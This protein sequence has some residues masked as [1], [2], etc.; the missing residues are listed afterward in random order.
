[1]IWSAALWD[2]RHG[3]ET[4]LERDGQELADL[5]RSEFAQRGI[6]FS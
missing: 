1:M 3:Y 5:V 2:V 6:E 4:A